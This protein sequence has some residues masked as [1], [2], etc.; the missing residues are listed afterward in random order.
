MLGSFETMYSFDDIMER[1]EIIRR[2]II[3]I[4]DENAISKINLDDIGSHILHLRSRTEIKKGTQRRYPITIIIRE[5]M[6]FRYHRYSNGIGS[7]VK[8]YFSK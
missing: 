1:L 3:P 2:R 8:D 5:L 6:T 7:A 4:S